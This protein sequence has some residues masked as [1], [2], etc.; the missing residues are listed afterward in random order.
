M[1]CLEAN[2]YND[3]KEKSLFSLK[4]IRD[5]FT[6]LGTNEQII[7]VCVFV[8]FVL[9]ENFCFFRTCEEGNASSKVVRGSLFIL[10]IRLFW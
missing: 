6:F 3:L 9:L 2:K 1:V 7:K 10:A 4:I 8:F 5:Y